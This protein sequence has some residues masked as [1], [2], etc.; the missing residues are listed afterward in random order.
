MRWT[1]CQTKFCE[2]KMIIEGIHQ[3]GFP[4][5][6]CR[7]GKI[8]AENIGFPQVSLDTSRAYLKKQG[9]RETNVEVGKYGQSIWVPISIVR[10]VASILEEAWFPQDECR[11]GKIWAE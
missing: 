4:R 6:E 5:D 9:S 1:N 3:V 7:S 8:W 10:Y 2:S 11:S